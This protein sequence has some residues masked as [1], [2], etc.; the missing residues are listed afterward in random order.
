MTSMLGVPGR[1][2]SCTIALFFGSDADRTT[3][4][5]PNVA[6]ARSGSN[7]F[8]FA[9][10]ECGEVAPGLKVRRFDFNLVAQ[11]S[12]QT[13]KGVRRALRGW[14]GRGLV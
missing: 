5:T 12:G 11:G 13:V 10:P 6:I 3:T 9:G 2:R 7:T 14:L 1:P 8:V 4:M